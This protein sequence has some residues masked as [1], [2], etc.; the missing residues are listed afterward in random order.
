[1]R[2][3]LLRSL[4]TGLVPAAWLLVAATCQSATDGL[5]PGA[6]GAASE[7]AFSLPDLDGKVH[8][9]VDA[10]GRIVVLE[11]ISHRCPTVA[12]HYE[13]RIAQETRTAVRGDDVVWWSIDSSGVDTAERPA[14]A[15]WRAQNGHD[16]PWLLDRDGTVGRAF[17]AERT[18]HVFVLDAKGAVAYAGAWTDRDRE[19]D[20]V[21]AAVAALRAGL[22]VTH[23]RTRARGCTIQYADGAVESVPAPAPVAA[24]SGPLPPPVA[25][26]LRYQSAGAHAAAG[27][28]DAALEA[29]EGAFASGHATPA[30]V[31][32]D[33]AFAALRA[34]EPSRRSLS[35]L[36]RRHAV[37][38]RL[39]MVAADE[40][41][42]P[43]LLLGEVRDAAGRPL[44]G[45][46]VLV[47][48]TD[49]RGLYSNTGDDNPRLFAWLRTDG[50]GCFA[51]RTI[52]PAAYPD[53]A[54]D[55]H[56]HFV[57]AA[58]GHLQVERRIGFADDPFW[59]TLAPEPRPWIVAVERADD[60]LARCRFTLTV[61]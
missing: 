9:L 16:V 57:L 20:Y 21:E 23:A 15:A 33:P 61:P 22:P 59:R 11:W 41:G 52:R 26:W 5:A 46:R 13:N 45:A 17:G 51:V 37:Q 28:L 8:R 30:D 54:I 49:S 60:G 50:D 34:D 36:L 24:A 14:I 29:L 3:S 4:A 39:T 38:S 12:F 42:E 31:H 35:A 32:V 25:A 6:T 7:Q 27:R 2:R 56:V 43:M 47:Y 55:Q 48:H 10:R 1:M 58:E 40:P 19:V 18:P 53:Q 44:P